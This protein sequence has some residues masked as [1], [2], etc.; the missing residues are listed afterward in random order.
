MSSPVI[1]PDN[2]ASHVGVEMHLAATATPIV[3]YNMRTHSATY[4]A[5]GW[6]VEASND[7]LNWETV[8]LRSNQTYTISGAYY[9]YDN[10][11]YTKGTDNNKEFFHFAN[12]RIGGLA[13]MENPLSVQIDGGGTLD[14]L[15]FDDGQEVDAITVDL[16]A[17]AGTLRGGR[18]VA[19]GT[20][21]LTGVEAAGAD[22][23]LPLPLAF[24]GTADTDNFATWTVV[25]DGKVSR[26]HPVFADGSL[27]VPCTGFVLSVR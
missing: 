11:A 2:P 4:Y 1:D 24:D 25:I 18:I 15:A 26:R 8:E 14:L 10:V 6:K 19:N 21:T 9:S 20:L 16:A 23:T 22:I 7:G 13:S 27:S 17:G 12:Y 5:D 3:G